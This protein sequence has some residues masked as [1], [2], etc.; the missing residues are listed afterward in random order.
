MA[1]DLFVE[2]FLANVVTLVTS[3]GYCQ[4]LKMNDVRLSSV[5]V[6]E[7]GGIMG[8]GVHRDNETLTL[9]AAHTLTVYTM[10]E[11]PGFEVFCIGVF[12]STGTI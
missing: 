7:A 12:R 9:S 6:C 10:G 4:S 3:Y 2:T 1:L 8:E 11:R 5:T